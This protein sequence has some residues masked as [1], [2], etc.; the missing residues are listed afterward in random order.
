MILKSP[1]QFMV[2]RLYLDLELNEQLVNDSVKKL[3]EWLYKQPH[4]PQIDGKY[5]GAYLT[6]ELTFYPVTSYGG[7][8]LL[9]F[10]LGGI[11]SGCLML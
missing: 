7:I 6:T 10:S 9:F 11:R 4:L 1:P 3:K 5:N 8:I 2:D